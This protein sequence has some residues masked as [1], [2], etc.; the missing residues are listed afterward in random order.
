MRIVHVIAGY[1]PRLGGS[2][3][4]V[5]KISEGLA[6]RGHHVTVLTMLE[7]ETG[8]SLSAPRSE[9][10]NSVRVL[11]FPENTALERCLKLRGAYRLLRAIAPAHRVRMM[12]R[13]PLSLRLFMELL[14]CKADLVGVFGWWASLLPFTVALAKRFRPW[15]M[16]GIPLFHTEEAWSREATY[17]PLLSR[18]DAIITN[19][20]YEQRFVEERL[21]RQARVLVSGVGID[22]D[23][24]ADRDGQRIRTRYSMGRGPVVG[25]VGRIVPSKGIPGL[26]KAMR[27]VWRWNPDVRLVLAGP[28][29]LVGMRADQ[30]I[31]VALAGLSD[32]ER[33]RVL[34]LGEFDERDKASIYDS[35]DVFAM[36]STG[37]SFGI[38]YLEAWMCGKPVIGANVGSTPSV[39]RDGVDGLLVDPQ[40]P[41]HIGE[42]IVRLLKNPAERARLG[43]AGYTRTVSEFTWERVTDRVEGFYKQL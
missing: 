19:T 10:V 29:T 37:E 40:D 24:F 14:R 30:E 5:Q 43:Q 28:R 4:H 2:E 20:G 8:A 1:S 38:A 25:Y 17:P 34:S 23:A 13:G 36:P 39:I 12:T 42:A 22:P 3:V 32:A 7:R 6:R 15:R 16:V 11:R 26:I 33:A 27:V 31:D 41:E 35:L 18:C 21:A 9:L